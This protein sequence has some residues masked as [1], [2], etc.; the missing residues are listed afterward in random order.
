MSNRGYSRFRNLNIVGCLRKKWLTNGGHVHPRIPPPRNYA[1]DP[2]R[3][4]FCTAARL[5]HGNIN[6]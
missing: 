2:N 1:L 5:R 4:R 3:A 6:Y